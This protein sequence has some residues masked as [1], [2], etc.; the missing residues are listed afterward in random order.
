MSPC[1]Y[2][3]TDLL[4]QKL[5]LNREH[6]PFYVFASAIR[7]QI[8]PQG[9]FNKTVC[10]ILFLVTILLVS[11]RRICAEFETIRENV[12]KVPES[13]E[14]MIQIVD[15]IHFTKT[16]GIAE[17]NEKMQVNNLNLTLK[18]FEFSYVHI[19]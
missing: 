14:E 19:F 11:L 7:Y 10:K 17:L 18:R 8:L 16:K 13:T 3:R 9:T 12:L 5:S 1:F 6:S 15:H 2:S 4:I